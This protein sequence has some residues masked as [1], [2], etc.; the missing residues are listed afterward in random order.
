MKAFY[1]YTEE[2][3]AVVDAVDGSVQLCEQQSLELV[4]WRHL[5]VPGFKLDSLIRHQIADA[6]FLVADITIPNHNVFYE[7]GYA[8][9]L[10]K[11]VIPT[12]N[13]A[14]YRAKETVQRLGLFDTIGWATYH[15]SVELASQLQDWP[16]TSW[17][18]ALLR[19]R[20]YAQP[21]FILDTMAKTD[22]RNHIFHTVTNSEVNFRAFDPTEI[23][24]L[25]AGK[26]VSE[27]SSS[28]GVI[29]CILQD[30]ILDNELNN[31]RASFIL[32]LC[33]GYELDALALQY[34]DG[35]AP[36]DYREFI[37][38]TTHRWET[39]RHVESYCTTTLIQNQQASARHRR[40]TSG[41]LNE[42]DLGSPTAE[43]ETQ[44]LKY[45]FIKT[46]EFSRALR[47]EGAIV[48][49]RKGAGKSAVYLQVAETLQR[50]RSV[51]V[52]DLRPASHNL[53]EMRQALLD[54]LSAGVFDHTIAAFWQYIMYMEI[55][56]E[57]RELVLP[58]ARNDFR[59]QERIREC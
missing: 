56:L 17:S 46:A 42:I 20:D 39:V 36:L 52:V 41:I 57:I 15:N 9:A 27:V 48:T 28:A 43:N 45:Y 12:L 25:S 51:C 14:L 35:P 7:I 3:Q 54:V 44:Q 34:G 30:D 49:G 2:S 16:S 58:R 22:F 50:E 47:A 10:G 21:L 53:S 23:P 24:R 4:L 8:I 5:T 1:A 38:N 29:V 40:P 55:L 32:G 11:P 26:A 18:N 33:H 6:D 13:V 31:L 37:T 59:L 19:K